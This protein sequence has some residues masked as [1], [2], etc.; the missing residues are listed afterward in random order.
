[1]LPNPVAAAGLEDL[2]FDPSDH[3]INRSRIEDII[4]A[5]PERQAV[6]I[7]IGGDDSIAI[8]VITA[9]RAHGLLTVLQIDAHID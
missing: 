1:M 2:P 9:Y 4:A 3:S 5:A 7:V 8:P 6:P